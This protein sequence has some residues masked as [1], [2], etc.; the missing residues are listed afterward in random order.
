[1]IL[2][3]YQTARAG[4]LGVGSVLIMLLEA[5]HTE[6]SRHMLIARIASAGRFYP[7]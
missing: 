4:D 3:R 1:M 7:T 2:K 5:L 6:A